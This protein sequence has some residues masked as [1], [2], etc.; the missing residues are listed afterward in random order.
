[1]IFSVSACKEKNEHGSSEAGSSTASTV[2]DTVIEVDPT[3]DET[4][5]VPPTGGEIR[6]SDTD[7]PDGEGI[8]ANTDTEQHVAHTYKKAVTPA[9][10]ETDG[11]TTYT[12]DCGAK[13]T[14]ETVLATGHKYGDWK[15]VA[16]PTESSLGKEE[17]VCGSCSKKET[18]DIP[19]L[20]SGH[21]HSYSAVITKKATCTSEGIKTFSCSCGAAYT[22][23]IGKTEHKYSD[24]VVTPTCATPGYT[25]HTCSVCSKTYYDNNVKVVPHECVDTVVAPTCTSEGYTIHICRFC[26]YKFSDS[27]TDELGHDYQNETVS[28]TCTTDGY[29]SHTCKRCGEHYTDSVVS[30][31]G[32]RNLR[33]ESKAPKCMFDGYERQVCTDCGA[34]V[35]EVKIPETGVHTYVAKTCTE[36][37]WEMVEYNM[38]FYCKNISNYAHRAD[39]MCN[40]CTQCH[41]IK[42]GKDTDIWSMYTDEE[43]SKRMLGYVNELRRQKKADDPGYYNI[44]W[45]KV[46]L[47][48]DEKLTEL[49]NIRAKEISVMYGHYEHNTTRTGAAECIAQGHNTVEHV[50]DAWKNS[51]GHYKIMVANYGVRFGYGR[52]VNEIGNVFHVLLVWDR[53][54]DAG[55]YDD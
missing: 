5:D 51:P 21:T 10:C 38:T 41:C 40:I 20:I 33:A 48:Y 9:T 43:Q 28:A 45:D 47:V 27:K 29:T 26:W 44:I 4:N 3:G 15:E 31:T 35:S 18:R 12:C 14:D 54:H 55:N 37:Y 32:H 8:S 19:K 42:Y 25:K 49:A 46:E 53:E 30:A 7:T 22:E 52:Y 50:F 16:A 24:T 17:R 11:F 1:M 2:S 34:T 23:T 36:A 39:L 6:G 13:Y